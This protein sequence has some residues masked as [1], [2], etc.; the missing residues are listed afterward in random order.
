MTFTL[1]P[2]GL[3]VDVSSDRAPTL[4]GLQVSIPEDAAAARWEP[5]ESQR[6]EASAVAA[7]LRQ[8]LV[9]DDH[10]VATAVLEARDDVAELAVTFHEA[11]DLPG[12]RDTFE[13]TDVALPGFRAAPDLR[14]LLVTHGL[15]PSGDGEVGGYWPEAI[16]GRLGAGLGSNAFQP[17]VLFDATGALAVAPASQFLTSSLVPIEGGIARGLHASLTRIPAA[18]TVRTLFVSGSDP[19]DALMRLGDILLER[20]GKRRPRSDH[21]PMTRSLGWWNAYGGYYTEPIHPLDA[22]ELSNVVDDLE[23]RN[24]PVRYLGLDL[25]YPYA[26]IGQAIRFSPDTAK[27]P[28]GIASVSKPHDLPTVLHL[29]ALSRENA[30]LADGADPSFYRDVAEELR[31]QGAVV[32]WHDWL[33]TQQHLTPAL[34]SD[35]TVADRWFDGM[36]E[37]MAE[38]GIDVLTCM[39]TMGMVLKSTTLPNVIAS[40]SSIDYLFSQ[41]AAIDTLDRIGE[42]GFRNEAT[43]PGRM[44]RQNLLVGC[45][46]YSLGLLPF[47]DLFLTRWHEEVGG[48]DPLEEAVLR[49]LS[50]GP[51][52]IGDAPGWADVDL[53]SSLV[54]AGG[55]LLQPDRPPFPDPET[56]GEPIEIYRTVR[57]AGGAAWEYVLLLNA[58]DESQTFDVAAG[59]HDTLIWDGLHG[60][61]ASDTAGLLAP[62]GLG[63]YV[64][65]PHRD[66]IAPIGLA[67][68]LVLAPAD[69]LLRA[70]W[71]GAWTIDLGAAGET[72]VVHA[73]HPLVVTDQDG[74]SLEIERDG[75]LAFIPVEEGVS[76]L[77]IARR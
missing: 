27:Y 16:V 6:A 53:V 31:H 3:H 55:T 22:D 60:A 52:G 48:T 49:A 74:A 36:A 73:P 63:Y 46:L 9:R 61:V 75:P 40:R 44:R 13:R 1:H 70:T 2:D 41:A 77:R 37:A 45:V 29:S 47:H 24:V 33:R 8:S 23:K 72:F 32:A 59:R 11:L 19:V 42:G 69:V 39:H 56:L 62:G 65:V 25:W 30:Y 43:T 15:G 26:A 4:L 12:D 66:G 18:T 71:D 64:L 58:T 76:S 54:S 50:C 5:W 28:D 38:H 17:L 21:S 10:V 68:K 51:V 7:H 34:R 20:G 14:Y 35:M 67:G 57:D